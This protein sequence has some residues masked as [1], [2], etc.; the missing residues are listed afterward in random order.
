MAV[1]ERIER[2]TIALEWVNEAGWGI[3][4]AEET[5]FIKAE[6]VTGTHLAIT[7]ESSTWISTCVCTGTSMK[8]GVSKKCLYQIVACAR[9]V[10]HSLNGRIFLGPVA[11]YRSTA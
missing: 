10:L 5:K 8:D 2:R 11:C 4:R 9:S 7:G 3:R 1:T 6:E